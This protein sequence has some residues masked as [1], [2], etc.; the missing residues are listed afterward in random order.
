MAVSYPFE[1]PLDTLPANTHW[2]P[3]NTS[4]LP[5]AYKGSSAAG[6][7]TTYDRVRV[8]S[9]QS[10]AD[11]PL[12]NYHVARGEQKTLGSYVGFE[13]DGMFAGWSGCESN[14]GLPFFKSTKE[15]GVAKN[16]PDL[17]PLGKFGYD[18]RCRSWY[19]E[20]A[21][22]ENDLS[23]S[24]PYVFASS[25]IVA[26]SAG[27][28][29]FDPQNRSIMVGESLLDFS[30]APFIE[31]VSTGTAVGRRDDGFGIVIT[32]QPDVSTK[33]DCPAVNHSDI[34]SIPPSYLCF[35]SYIMFA[36][37]WH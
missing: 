34:S 31:A 18:A 3:Q 12:F 24:P 16:R 21:K 13:A 27:A 25:N 29:L 4:L 1:Y 8:L 22:K 15:N 37:R 5:G 35:F 20:G 23:I 19:V 32:P 14:A 10:V 7:E 33:P 6:Y 17:C 2:W 26:M 36:G 11:F 30:P 9:A 28:S